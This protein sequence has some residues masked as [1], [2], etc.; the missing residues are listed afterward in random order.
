MKKVLLVAALLLIASSTY[1]QST[2]YTNSANGDVGIGTTSPASSLDMSQKSDALALPVGTTGQEPASP[3]SGMIRYNSTTPGVEAFYSGGWNTLGVGI[4]TTILPNG[5]TA[6]TQSVNDS[7]TN[8]ATTAF[9]N[10]ASSIGASGYVELP[11]GLIEEWGDGSTS[12]SGSVAVTFPFAFPNN[13]FQVLVSAPDVT[14]ST[15]FV[16]S[17]GPTTT[18]FDVSGW[19]VSGSRAATPYNYFAIGN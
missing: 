8:V 3:V 9:A 15:A 4:G 12:T 6:T 10:P 11:S 18:G 17:S 14:T 7:S 13:V 5:T 16:T 1:A 2:L 19:A